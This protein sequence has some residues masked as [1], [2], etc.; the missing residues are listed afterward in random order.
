VQTTATIDINAA[1]NKLLD[2]IITDMNGRILSKKQVQVFRGN[3]KTELRLDHLPAGIYNIILSNK[4]ATVFVARF[5][6]Q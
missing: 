3:N 4:S 2:Y 5:A 1:E 6:K